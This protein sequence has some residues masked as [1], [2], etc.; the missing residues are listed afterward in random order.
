MF[1]IELTDTDGQEVQEILNKL[2]KSKTLTRN[3]PILTFSLEIITPEDLKE[4]QEVFKP[5]GTPK[6]V[7]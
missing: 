4:Q 5:Q 6:G 7:A 1:K 3:T 2:A